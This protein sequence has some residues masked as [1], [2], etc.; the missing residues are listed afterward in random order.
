MR[1]HDTGYIHPSYVADGYDPAG[2]TVLMETSHGSTILM[3][4]DQYDWF[5]ARGDRSWA[6][7]WWW[8]HPTWIQ[9][10]FGVRRKGESDD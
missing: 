7:L 10:L 2:P 3:N 8:D 1:I 9:R 5:I 6:T 4:Q